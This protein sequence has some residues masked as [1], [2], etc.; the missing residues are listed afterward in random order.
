MEVVDLAKVRW[1]AEGYER[2]PGEVIEVSDEQAESLI[3]HGMAE[4]VEE[5]TSNKKKGGDG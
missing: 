3:A 1:V 5:P 4:P 2:R